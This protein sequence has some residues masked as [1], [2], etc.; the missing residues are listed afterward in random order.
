MARRS[1]ANERGGLWP[2]RNK[3]ATA[4]GRSERNQ[5]PV[6]IASIGY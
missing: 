6:C 1:E 2:S 4:T 3:L 5:Q